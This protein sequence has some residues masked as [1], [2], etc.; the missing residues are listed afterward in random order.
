MKHPSPAKPESLPAPPA[1]AALK[2]AAKRALEEARRTG[3]A[4]YVLEGEMLVDIAKRKPARR[5]AG[6]KK[7]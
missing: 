4:C 6:K 7:K 2:R 5:S 1:F 3:T